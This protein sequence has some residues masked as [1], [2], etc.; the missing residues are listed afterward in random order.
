MSNGGP[1]SQAVGSV[2]LLDSSFTNTKVGFNLARTSSSSP[3]T[4]GSLAIENLALS[5]VP[6]AVQGPNNA[7]YLAGTTG[8]TT[9]AGWQTGNAYTPNGPKTTQGSVVPPTRPT[10][11][12]VNGKYY[13]RSKPQYNNL[14]VSSFSSVRAGGAKGDGMTDD[15]TALQNVI[16]SAVSA[17]KVVF[18]D[19]GTYKVTK[20][21][22]IPK[23][24]KIVGESY[25]VIM[26]AGSFFADIKN[27]KAVVQV[28]N[29]GDTGVVEWS[30]MMVSTQGAQAGAVLIKW[31]L[32]ST[33]S[34]P[35]GMWDVHTRIG[36][37]KGSNLTLA[38]CP[39]TPTSAAVNT[40]CIAAYMS[41]HITK[42]ASSLYMENVWLWVAD[43]DVDDS[44]L[45]Q[46][47]IYAGR[48]LYIESTAGTFWLV[49]TAVEHHT[50]Y[51]YQL[52][53]TNNIFMGQIQ[54]E[55]PYYQPNPQGAKPFSTVNTTI[56]DPNFGT[57]CPSGSSPT[58]SNAFGLRLVGSSNIFV[59][60]AGLYSFFN[61]YSTNCS[62]ADASSK[63]QPNIFTYD[64]AYTKGLY[65]Q[66]L[67]TVGTTNMVTRDA[68]SL[69]K[70]SD[71]K[72]MYPSTIVFFKSG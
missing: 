30:D 21:I 24:S 45:K 68:T 4:G 57:Y 19:A 53:S 49:G 28:G 48:G 62:N 65:V 56:N 15:T 59:Y 44:S 23:G 36:G 22:F 18:V 3:A 42:T 34:A 11:L 72:N 58:C 60:G 2:T 10:S 5:N 32:A 51:Q 1:S 61:N 43:H 52:A 39:T 64:S 38:N 20:T 41:M 35:S 67:N 25:S 29:P 37:F 7:V 6:V 54:T 40:N 69:A 71:D 70:F 55:T 26:S 12:V 31:N 8:K 66:N 50:L 13:E 16:N 46:I 14:P 47:T 63:C 9:V 33:P 27:P 17:G